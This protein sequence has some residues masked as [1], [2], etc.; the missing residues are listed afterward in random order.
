MQSHGASAK[1]S[2]VPAG[3][4]ILAGSLVVVIAVAVTWWQSS[5]QTGGANVSTRLLP[6]D[7]E[8][9]RAGG[10]PRINS[11]SGADVAAGGSPAPT[12]GPPPDTTSTRDP[13]PSLD[14][15]SEFSRLA[16]AGDWA[17]L[18][19]F[20]QNAILKADPLGDFL[21]ILFACL[22]TIGNRASYDPV[23]RAVQA[24]L[25]GRQDLGDWVQPLST[26]FL[27]SDSVLVLT[28]LAGPVVQANGETNNVTL[29]LRTEELLMSKNALLEGVDSSTVRSAFEGMLIAAHTGHAGS[30]LESIEFVES[31]K[32][33][34]K[35]SDQRY[36]AF[37]EN[38][39]RAS[40][41][42]KKYFVGDVPSI[43]RYL[44]GF[45]RERIHA[46][47]GEKR[48]IDG[49]KKTWSRLRE[50]AAYDALLTEASNAQDEATRDALDEIAGA[51]L[52]FEDD[53]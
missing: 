18:A 31:L 25:L 27:E 38:S 30:I 43:L 51:W 53:G 32:A 34:G 42:H 49:L 26:E 33:S 7:V 21:P 2:G 45:T 41:A 15:A 44:L 3:I 4:A 35:L 52:T 29:K 12:H 17:A 50:D 11:G 8:R 6:D 47:E 10:S 39:V 28:A 14:F 23:G 40:F 19:V 48:A 22:E 5:S 36:V 1:R 46:S 13:V 37:W 9:P 16:D 20:V 24:G